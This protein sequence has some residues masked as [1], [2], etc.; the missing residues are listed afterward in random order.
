M[1]YDW[2]NDA[3]PFN[4]ELE[5]GKMFTRKVGVFAKVLGGIGVDRPF[6]WGSALAI[7]WRF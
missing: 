6:D 7:R 2:V 3:V 5:F 1:P 4:F